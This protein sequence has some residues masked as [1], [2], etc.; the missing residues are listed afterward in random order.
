[1]TKKMFQTRVDS[2][3]LDEVSVLYKSLGTSVGDAFVM[4]LQN[5][6]EVNGLPFDLRKQVHAISDNPLERL[7]LA[8]SNVIKV[9]ASNPEAIADFFDEDYP[10]YE[11]RHGQL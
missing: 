3:L 6:K 2:E 1:M 5:S 8:N 9:T 7:A 11:E 10:E 4:F